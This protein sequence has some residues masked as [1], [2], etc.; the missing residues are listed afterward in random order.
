MSITMADPLHVFIDTNVWLSFYSFTN[1][2][3]EQLRKLIALVKA[4][5]L[6]LYTDDHLKD[7]FYRNRERKLDES[8]RDFSKGTIVKGVPRYMRDYPEAE[9]YSESVEAAAK[10]RDAM[11]TRTKE[12]ARAKI[13]AADKLFADILGVS[14][15]T[16]ADAKIMSAALDR[17]LKSNP[18]GKYPSLGDQIHWEILLR[19]VPE[20]VDLHV[21]SKDGDFESTLNKGVAHPFLVDEWQERKKGQMLLHNELRP[22]LNSKF[23]DIKLA[24]DVEKNAA[25]SKLIDAGNFQATHNA[26]DALSLF[27]NDLSWED[28]DK[29]FKAGLSN[30]QIRWIGSDKDVRE[31]YQLLIEKFKDKLDAATLEDAS[32]V[33]KKEDNPI[34][35][36]TADQVNDDMPF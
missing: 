22:F 14:P 13:L 6:K 20:G 26:I 8:I 34:D 12:E 23:P 28:A 7:E 21:V 19:D 30:T 2:D 3:L 11:I 10:L 15:P 36:G 18:P 25:M 5:K 9:K 27:K 1:D 29:L 31:F 4:D 33:F 16:K 17:R 24:V 32:K 35:W